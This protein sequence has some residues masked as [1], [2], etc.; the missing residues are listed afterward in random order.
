M[1]AWRYRALTMP[2]LLTLLTV[3]AAEPAPGHALVPNR[4]WERLSP[5]ADDTDFRRAFAEAGAQLGDWKIDFTG[6][7]LDGPALEA[8]AAKEPGEPFTRV[9]REALKRPV[10]VEDFAFFLDDLLDAGAHGLRG[11]HV[12]LG[13]GRARAVGLLVHPDEVFAGKP[14]RYGEG[15]DRVELD[16]PEDQ[17]SLEPAADGEPLGPRWT[18]R[19][20][21]PEGEARMLAALQKKS[22]AFAKRVQH[23]VGQL[24]DQGA[25]VELASTLRNRQRGYLMWGSFVLS[26]A[27]SAKQVDASVKMLRRYNTL[28]KHYVPIAWRAPGEWEATV[29]AARQM[30]DTYDVVYATRH[31]AQ[32]SDHYDGQAVDVVVMGLPRT[33]TLKAP[34]GA[35]Q[36]FD[37]SAPDEPRDLSLTPALVEWVEQ[38]YGFKKLR[39]DYPH[40]GDAVRR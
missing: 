34:D 31:G 39:A 35:S 7:E 8:L 2:A 10:D 19:Y 14:R 1:H 24:R 9:V 33:L 17:S 16:E 28:W 26:K 21:N 40:W 20:Q 37:L 23:L 22:P 13:T 25:D 6:L 36:S 30:K 32:F 4:T 29:E 12:W 5:A 27:T 15:M 3:L 11:T 38:H 18:T